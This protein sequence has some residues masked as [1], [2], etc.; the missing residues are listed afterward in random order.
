MNHVK[1]VAMTA[2]VTGW[3][4]LNQFGVISR[5]QEELRTAPDVPDKSMFVAF[6][7]LGTP[8]AVSPNFLRE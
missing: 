4:A 1:Q 2:C 6:G 3:S 7:E 8:D 5:H